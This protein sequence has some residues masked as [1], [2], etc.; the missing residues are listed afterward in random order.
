MSLT[1]GLPTHFS[2]RSH[3]QGVCAASFWLTDVRRRSQRPHSC[4]AVCTRVWEVPFTHPTSTMEVL[5]FT[6]WATHLPPSLVILFFPSLPRE[7][8]MVSLHIGTPPRPS[9][10]PAPSPA[11][12]LASVILPPVHIYLSLGPAAQGDAPNLCWW[13]TPGAFPGVL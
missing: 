3:H 10:F 12:R 13:S 5:F 4:Q 11:G 1:L 2:C 7:A 6:A 8:G 9:F